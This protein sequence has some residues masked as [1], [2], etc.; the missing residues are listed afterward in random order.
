M[1][2]KVVI[3]FCPACGQ[4][5]L[6]LGTGARIACSRLTCPRPTAADE[7]LGTR[8]LD[9]IVVTTM[10]DYCMQHPL[11]ERLDGELFDCA[12]SQHLESL[13]GAPVAPGR[14]RVISAED[15]WVWEPM[16]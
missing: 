3:G 8:E 9:H 11:I 6:F 1:S 10:T 15:D 12:L 16:T 13:D 5:T 14:Y 4:E 7:I 2:N